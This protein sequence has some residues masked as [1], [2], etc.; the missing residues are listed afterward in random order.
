[1]K[2]KGLNLPHIG[3]QPML[4][5]GLLAFLAVVAA[6]LLDVRHLGMSDLW[7]LLSLAVLWPVLVVGCLLVFGLYERPSYVWFPWGTRATRQGRRTANRQGVATGKDAVPRLMLAM[8]LAMWTLMRLLLPFT[9]VMLEAMG[10][11]ICA[12]IVTRLVFAYADR[13]KR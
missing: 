8:Y 5:E 1:M 10:F 4:V 7:I 13:R 12:V 9:S 3:R 6:A 2:A 11:T